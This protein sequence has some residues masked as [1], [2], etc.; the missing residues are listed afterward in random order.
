MVSVSD[1]AYGAMPNGGS[2]GGTMVMFADPAVLQGSG[3]V[4]IMEASSTKIQRVVR[5]SMSAEVSSLATAFEHGDYVR[6]VFAELI[7]PNF[8][9]ERWKL[10]ASKWRHLLVTD[11]KTGYDAVS[12]EVLPSDRKIAIEVGV[13]RQGL[14]EPDTR[15][16]IRWVPGSEMPGDGLTKWAHN[17]VLT[18]VMQEGQWSLVDT[19]EAQALRRLAATKRAAWRSQATARQKA[20]GGQ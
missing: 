9:I 11:A 13:L 8:R 5:C 12:S 7:D 10:S 4:C 6:A 15:N 19:Q 2:Q 16:F 3:A 20:Q 17:H 14:L 18:R 1:A